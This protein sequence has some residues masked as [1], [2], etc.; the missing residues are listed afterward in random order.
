MEIKV[1]VRNLRVRLGRGDTEVLGRRR[2]ERSQ[3]G[4]GEKMYSTDC[5]GRLEEFKAK[6]SNIPS[7]V[8][9]R[10]RGMMEL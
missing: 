4:R 5:E 10:T 7:R 3:G 8:K 6:S 9:K 1:T 2:L